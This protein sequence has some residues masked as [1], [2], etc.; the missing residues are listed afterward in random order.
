MQPLYVHG[1]FNFKRCVC[2]D[3]PLIGGGKTNFI[4]CG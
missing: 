4:V 3:E 1:Y 2:Y